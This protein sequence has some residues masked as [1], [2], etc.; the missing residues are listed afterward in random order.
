MVSA[1]AEAAAPG[2]K[3]SA[4]LLERLGVLYFRRMSASLPRVSSSDAVSVLN[5]EERKA[6]A[7]IVRGA[8]LRACLAGASSAALAAGAEVLADQLFGPDH[9]GLDRTV[10]YWALV[11]GVTVV[12]AV[13]EILFLYWDSLRAVHAMARA[14]GL[15]PFATGQSDEQSAVASAL[16]RAALE[17]PNP[18]ESVFGVDPRRESSRLKLAIAS[19]L[20]KVK[21][22]VT[23]FAVKVLVRRLAGRAL[24]R[25]WLPFVAVPG[26]A[27]W[28]GV[29]CYVVLREARV[30]VMGPSAARELISAIFDQGITPSPE[31]R[32]AL[33]R[34]VASSIVRTEDLHPNLH[35]V[36]VEV[37]RRVDDPLPDG[38]DDSRAFLDVVG[39][40]RPDEQKMA[41]QVL[42]A[43]AIIDGRFTGAEE[44]LFLEALSACGQAPDRRPAQRLLRAFMRGDGSLDTLVRSIV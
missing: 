11:G 32:V 23:N 19:L 40:L 3:A 5:A 42:A 30:R 16:A 41:L 15:D 43:A 7:G 31:G 13:L 27:A 10:R 24:V 8:V 12:A 39:R 2:G 17:L 20:Y 22:S 25:T 38:I 35:A 1:G 36:L 44:R 37:L 14:A 9:A 34:A 26:T 29:V 6:L 18:T 28:N 33:V 21:V 4:P